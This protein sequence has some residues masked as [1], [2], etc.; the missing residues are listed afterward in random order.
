[1]VSFYLQSLAAISSSGE[2]TDYGTVD[3][4]GLG[5]FP[6]YIVAEYPLWEIPTFSDMPLKSYF[7]IGGGYTEYSIDQDPLTGL[8]D[9]TSSATSD[10]IDEDYGVIFSSWNMRLKQELPLFGLNDMG[11]SLTVTGEYYG[12][13]QQGIETISNIRDDT[14]AISSLYDYDQ[15]LYGTPDLESNRYFL[16]TSFNLALSL[17]FPEFLGF[18]TSLTNTSYYSPTWMN[19]VSY[20][21][22]LS[23]GDEYNGASFD[24]FKNKSSL[25]ESL[26][27]FDT[28]YTDSIS[29]EKLTKAKLKFYHNTS[30]NYLSGDSIPYYAQV[31]D[32]YT[33]GLSD[34]FHLTFEGPHTLSADTYPYASIYYYNTIDWGTL[35]NVDPDYADSEPVLEFGTDNLT[36]YAG[37]ELHYKFLGIFHASVSQDIDY[38]YD[39]KSWSL[40]DMEF[41]AYVSI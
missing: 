37:L 36:T 28:K 11:F 21:E 31:N 30:F 32:N 25:T 17:G 26:T 18:S 39:D 16:S 13:W 33:Y 22:F 40:D 29:G 14:S 5:T 10:L 23:N 8:S 34:S 27:I 19:N 24:F 12:R 38:S 35:H 3:D 7:D 15:T 4:L 41:S 9:P 1:M 20:F 2:V 6:T